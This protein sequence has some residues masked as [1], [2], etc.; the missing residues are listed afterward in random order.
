MNAIFQVG[1]EFFIDDWAEKWEFLKLT[2]EEFYSQVYS[3]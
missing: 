1:I 3:V 2:N